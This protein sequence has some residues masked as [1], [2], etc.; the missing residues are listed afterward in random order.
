M[1]D[2]EYLVF[3]NSA[4]PLDMNEIPVFKNGS[5]MPWSYYTSNIETDT[6]VTNEARKRFMYTSESKPSAAGGDAGVHVSQIKRYVQTGITTDDYKAIT[7]NDP[8]I[9]DYKSWGWKLNKDQDGNEVLPNYGEFQFV[10]GFEPSYEDI[11]NIKIKFRFGFGLGSQSYNFAE[12]TVTVKVYNLSSAPKIYTSQKEFMDINYDGVTDS[13][14]G[15]T[16]S[17]EDTINVDLKEGVDDNTNPNKSFVYIAVESGEQVALSFPFN[18]TD[19][20]FGQLDFKPNGENLTLSDDLASTTDLSRAHRINIRGDNNEPQVAL[21]GIKFDFYRLEVSAKTDYQNMVFNKTNNLIAYIDVVP[22]TYG[23]ELTHFKRT[24][25]VNVTLQKDTTLPKLEN[26][27]YYDEVTE[28]MKKHVVSATNNNRQRVIVTPDEAIHHAIATNDSAAPSFVRNNSPSDALD[29]YHKSMLTSTETALDNYKLSF[30]TQSMRENLAL[31]VAQDLSKSAEVNLSTWTA[32]SQITCDISNLLASTEVSTLN[33]TL[34]TEL[35][36]KNKAITLANIKAN[37]VCASDFQSLVKAWFTVI[38]PLNSTNAE[39]NAYDNSE[40][41]PWM[42]TGRNEQRKFGSL[43][44][45]SCGNHSDVLISGQQALGQVPDTSGQRATLM[46]QE[47]TILTL[48]Y[49]LDNHSKNGSDALVNRYSAD[50]PKYTTAT[51]KLDRLYRAM[52]TEYHGEKSWDNTITDASGASAKRP[53]G[54]YKDLFNYRYQLNPVDGVSAFNYICNVLKIVHTEAGPD[55]VYY[56]VNKLHD[57]LNIPRK[58]PTKTDVEALLYGDQ[59]TNQTFEAKLIGG[60]TTFMIDNTNGGK[61]GKAELGNTFLSGKRRDGFLNDANNEKASVFY[62]SNF[63]TVGFNSDYKGLADHSFNSTRTNTADV[64]NAA[65]L[66]KFIYNIGT[67]GISVYNEA[68]FHNEDKDFSGVMRLPYSASGK[69]TDVYIVDADGNEVEIKETIIDVTTTLENDHGP[70]SADQSRNM[71]MSTSDIAVYTTVTQSV[72]DL[73]KTNIK[74]VTQKFDIYNAGI[75]QVYRLGNVLQW[76]ANVNDLDAE[77]LPAMT[78]P[79]LKLKY[80]HDAAKEC[81]N[82]YSENCLALQDVISTLDMSLNSTRETAQGYNVS[83]DV[84]DASNIVVASRWG[85]TYMPIDVSGY[86]ERGEEFYFEYKKDQFGTDDVNITTPASANNNSNNYGTLVDLP[87]DGEAHKFT[88]QYLNTLNVDADWVDVTSETRFSYECHDKN[89]NMAAGTRNTHGDFNSETKFTNTS[90]SNVKGAPKFRLCLPSQSTLLQIYQSSQPNAGNN[91]LFNFGSLK[92]HL[93]LNLKYSKSAQLEKLNGSWSK[94]IDGNDKTLK[95]DVYVKSDAYA[96]NIKYQSISYTQKYNGLVKTI[97]AATTINTTF[98]E[99]SQA[100]DF[101]TVGYKVKSVPGSDNQLEPDY[102]GLQAYD[103]S[104]QYYGSKKNTVSF[105]NATVDENRYGSQAPIAIISVDNYETSFGYSASAKVVPLFQRAEDEADWESNNNVFCKLDNTFDSTTD[106]SSGSQRLIPANNNYSVSLLDNGTK[107]SLHR[108]TPLNYEQWIGTNGDIVNGHNFKDGNNLAYSELVVVK[109]TYYEPN[110]LF[111]VRG[112]RKDKT[113]IIRVTPQDI[114]EIAWDSTFEYVVNDGDKEVDISSLLSATVEGKSHDDIE[115]YVRGFIDESGTIHHYS[116]L[117]DLS[118]NADS[119]KMDVSNL[120]VMG[121]TT[122]QLNVGLT[123]GTAAWTFN[124]D[125]AE[126]AEVAKNLNDLVVNGKL[127]LYPNLSATTGF[128]AWTMNSYKILVEAHL[129]QNG[130]VAK[131]KALAL[132]SIK[133]QQGPTDFKLLPN[134][135][136]YESVTETLGTNA[137]GKTIRENNPNTELRKFTD[138]IGHND[139]NDLYNPSDSVNGAGKTIEWKIVSIDDKLEVVAGNLYDFSKQIIRLKDIPANRTTETKSSPS[140]QLGDF[141]H[142]N[143]ERQS[144]YHVHIQA[145]ASKLKLLKVKKVPEAYVCE[146]GRAAAPGGDDFTGKSG[147][148]FRTASYIIEDTNAINVQ[149]N[150]DQLFYF[151]DPETNK[152]HGPLSLQPRKLSDL[153]AIKSIYNQDLLYSYVR[154]SV[155]DS[156]YTPLYKTKNF[157]ITDKAPKP[158]DCATFVFAIK[159]SDSYDKPK[160]ALQPYLLNDK[161]EYYSAEPKLQTQLDNGLIGVEVGQRNILYVYTDHIDLGLDYAKDF[162]NNFKIPVWHPEYDQVDDA[163]NSVLGYSQYVHPDMSIGSTNGSWNNGLRNG[164][165]DGNMN[166]SN[167]YGLYPNNG[168]GDRVIVDYFVE[169]HGSIDMSGRNEVSKE[170]LL[171]K[172]QVFGEPVDYSGT[173]LLNKVTVNNAS[174]PISGTDK[175]M[176]RLSKVNRAKLHANDMKSTLNEFRYTTGQLQFNDAHVP[177]VGDVYSFSIAAVT[178]VLATQND[179]SMNKNMVDYNEDFYPYIKQ[180]YNGVASS[181]LKYPQQFQKY[182]YDAS[183]ERIITLAYAIAN[184][185]STGGAGNFDVDLSSVYNYPSASQSTNDQGVLAVCRTHFKVRVTAK[186]T[187][188]TSLSASGQTASASGLN[189]DSGSIVDATLSGGI[190]TPKYIISGLEGDIKLFNV[191]GSV[192]LGTYKNGVWEDL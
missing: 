51:T 70:Q 64:S 37:N 19:L 163:N 167:R 93:E 117:G 120:K 154:H 101:K 164:T 46:G 103:L 82:L 185:N 5:V 2:V 66:G 20:S 177:K 36:A 181:T 77:I 6:T 29:Q 1:S 124:N 52:R 170:R 98:Q 80:R 63:T 147:T 35:T 16:S 118:N 145:C 42:D 175:R 38:N 105:V 73:R 189:F 83:S 85:N 39:I 127:K 168:N 28:K 15:L 191:A 112:Q 179:M 88:L 89:S 109:V 136:Y 180:D 158:E 79:T 68:N 165:A 161:A 139:I 160:V 122:A 94:D 74:D 23:T 4:Q 65:L 61:I 54:L 115:Y 183:G 135:F 49:A 69:Y 169:S 184:N 97:S 50:M 67:S 95:L 150:N 60:A 34:N 149:S 146:L 182:V 131:E 13:Y 22:K 62:K 41:M 90:S 17:V 171:N 173:L 32:S 125:V 53:V 30:N 140:T 24:I 47:S 172:P 92:R 128:D 156:G 106:A 59:N 81:V 192:I 153:T 143:Y 133:V 31:F 144:E 8:T 188:V 55:K 40:S 21:E 126:V 129:K 113:L 44:D 10:P 121:D 107:I 48:L 7:I 76:V 110:S 114:R 84:T 137:E 138:K 190:I 14:A 100:V 123:T 159:V 33:T 141:V 152:Y 187:T 56:G 119:I 78:M 96:A 58:Q 111:G 11:S 130:Q 25:K 132:V 162:D 86:L 134:I 155:T 27:F 157:A 26:T 99:S 43:R 186:E 9:A 12:E 57:A 108:N 178:N 72:K 91:E 176:Y 174:A 116:A 87:S 75:F 18:G 166:G 45:V 151:C 148:Q 104:E 102:T 71:D 3:E 142:F